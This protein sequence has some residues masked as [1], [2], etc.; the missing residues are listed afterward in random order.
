MRFLNL[1]SK[2][3]CHIILNSVF[4]YKWTEN[5]IC[6]TTLCV[7]FLCCLCS[8]RT[9][10]DISDLLK[11]CQ[12][13]TALDTVL[14]QDG[15]NE[16]RTLNNLWSKLA[17]QQWLMQDSSD[18]LPHLSSDVIPFFLVSYI[19]WIMV[20]LINIRKKEI[21][22]I[23]KT[24]ILLLARINCVNLHTVLHQKQ[25]KDQLS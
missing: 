18:S 19:H 1:Q 10:L 13:S 9:N 12:Q 7:V 4:N 16:L 11:V 5:S 17:W 21:L 6:V 14:H 20:L 24:N 3:T 2:V 25:S 15:F 8:L 23:F 22:A